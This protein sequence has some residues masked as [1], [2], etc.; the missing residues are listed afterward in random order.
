MAVIILIFFGNPGFSKD[1]K[2]R[3]FGL[4]GR[5]CS[6][7]EAF[8]PAECNPINFPKDCQE[9]RYEKVNGNFTVY[10]FG[11]QVDTLDVFCD[12]S[13]RN[14]DTGEAKTYLNIDSKSNFA[15]YSKERHHQA[16]GFKCESL[17][18]QTDSELSGLT[19]YRKG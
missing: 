18:L 10:P 4:S 11:N 1:A 3:G 13:D 15:K 8:L 9:I 19:H 14:G 2:Y 7:T 12:F 5:K 6:S 16:T 17:F